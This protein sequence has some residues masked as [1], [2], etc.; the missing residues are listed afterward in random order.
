GNS[1]T[2]TEVMLE[3]TNVS[4]MPT[5]T[6]CLQCLK[7]MVSGLPEFLPAFNFVSARKKGCF[8]DESPK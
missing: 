7:S 1:R 2:T 8:S 4:T 6:E 5:N 3:I